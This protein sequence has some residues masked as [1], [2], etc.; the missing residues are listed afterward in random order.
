MDT[1]GSIGDGHLAEV[2]AEVRDAMRQTGLTGAISFFDTEITEPE[3]FD[4]EETL[5][6]ITPTGG[7]GTSFH[8][9]FDYLREKLSAD[10]PKAILIFTDGYARW[11]AEKGAMGV[12]VLWLIRKGGNAD[13][14][15]GRVA[16]L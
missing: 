3:P 7:G 8:V 9:I 15:W 6:K 14:P 10:P 12:P 5:R 13:V 4:T 1:S 2:M 16:K 11:P